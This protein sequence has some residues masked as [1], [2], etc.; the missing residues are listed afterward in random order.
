MNFKQLETFYWAVKL[1]SFSSA[2][3]RLNSTQSTISMR[4]IELERDLGVELFDRTQRSARPTAKGRDL[5][6]YAEEALRLSQEMQQQMLEAQEAL[7]DKT[8][9]ISAGE[10]QSVLL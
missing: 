7:G 10:K 2:A 8:V 1:G 9:E 4:I 3:Q 6:Q 5:L